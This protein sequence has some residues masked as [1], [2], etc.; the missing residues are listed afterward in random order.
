MIF[1]FRRLR[2]SNVTYQSTSRGRDSGIESCGY[3]LGDY[4]Q[5]KKELKPLEVIEASEDVFSSSLFGM[6]NSKMLS[7]WL[8]NGQN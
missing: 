1:F 6:D 4:V 3:L 8:H 5:S 2:F 7:L